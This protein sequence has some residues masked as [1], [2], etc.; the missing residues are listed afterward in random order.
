M[1][2][3]IN[4]WDLEEDLF[5][6]K[7]ITE[8]EGNKNKAAILASTKMNRTYYACL[9]RMYTRMPYV[10]PRDLQIVIVEAHNLRTIY[11]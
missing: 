11:I 4:R 1:R 9:R 3:G 6:Q 7:C 5:L 2:L 10:K 8:C